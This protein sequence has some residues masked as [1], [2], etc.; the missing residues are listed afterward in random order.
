MD[1][2]QTI[3]DRVV[4]GIEQDGLKWFREWNTGAA[5]FSF[6]I[7]HATKKQYNGFNVMWLNTIAAEQGYE[8]NEWMTFKQAEGKGYKLIEGE[9]AK[10][11][12]QFCVYWTVSYKNNTTDKWY[13][14]AKAAQ[15]AGENVS[16]L[17]KLWN[18][19]QFYVFNIAQFE[20][21]T[22]ITDSITVAQDEEHNPIEAAEA[23]FANY[24]GKPTLKNGGDK[25]YYRPSTHHVQMPKMNDFKTADDYYKT[26][27][28][29][30]VH[31]TGHESLLKRKGV[32][33][34]HYF[35]S[36]EYSIEE[37]IAEIGSE[38][39][40]GMTGIAPTDGAENAQAYINGWL[41]SIKEGDAK[42]VVMAAQQ[43]IKAVERIIK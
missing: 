18:M 31:S 25:A 4:A 19:K 26:F 5:N 3:T 6:P 43:A 16:K 36:E 24:D 40:V 9:T 42:T 1:I 22:P 28:H 30:L 34:K 23:I 15:A 27:Y 21:V 38:F 10:D 8:H 37:L 14:N 7:N 2:Y 33:G 32:C 41:K 11:K 39:L 17:A 12:N 35:G 20:N 13:P 29:E